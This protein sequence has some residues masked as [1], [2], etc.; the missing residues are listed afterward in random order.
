MPKD[1]SKP[2]RERRSREAAARQ[3]ARDSRSTDEHL[4]V[5]LGRV[6]SGGARREVARLKRA[7]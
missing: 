1:N 2:A 3:A 6:G 4:N 7:A 5:L